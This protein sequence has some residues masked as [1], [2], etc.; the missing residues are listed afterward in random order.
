MRKGK[1][2]GKPAVLQL[3][4]QFLHVIFVA[5]TFGVYLCI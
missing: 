4:Q 2:S 5:V 1:K 3:T